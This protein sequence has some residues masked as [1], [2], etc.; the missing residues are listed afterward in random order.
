MSNQEHDQKKFGEVSRRDFIKYTAGTAACISLGSLSFGCGSSTTQVAGYPIDS[1]VST[2][3]TKTITFEK[4]FS[5]A[6]D[7]KNL[8]NVQDY[9]RYAYGVWTY[10]PG[11]TSEKRNDIM[12]AGY[13]Y[14]AST[15]AKQL[16][17]FY[18]ITDIHIT[19]K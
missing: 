6:M 7:P 9:A 4:T 14:P 19:D 10:G 13:T 3:V 18:S 1:A 11:L 12:G 8:Q 16:L 15:P 17:R 5:P 2:T